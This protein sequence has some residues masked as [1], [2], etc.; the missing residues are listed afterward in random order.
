MAVSARSVWTG[1]IQVSLVSVPVRA[2][3]AA[4]AGDAAIAFHQLHAECHNRVRYQKT[5]P[6]HGELR[7]DEIDRGY[8]FAK[9]Q[10][11]SSWTRTRCG[12]SARRAT[13]QSASW[14]RPARRGLTSG[15]TRGGRSTSR[16][17]AGGAS[18][19]FAADWRRS[20]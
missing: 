1:Y 19:G 14:G 9:D 11:T 12:C 18:A 6:V 17:A 13:R 2:Y 4:A 16:V 5:C 20:S 7:G 8:Q 15:S 10:C 3:N